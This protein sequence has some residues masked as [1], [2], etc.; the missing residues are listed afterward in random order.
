MKNRFRLLAVVLAFG[1]VAAACGDSYDRQELI[2]EL[3]TD[4][5]ITEEQATCMADGMEEQIGVDR[6][7]DRG[8]P[9]AEEEQV[10]ADIAIDCLL[11]S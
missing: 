11:G 8:N 6:L 1:S 5:G 7:N 3:V 4:T 10:M 2:D 9:T